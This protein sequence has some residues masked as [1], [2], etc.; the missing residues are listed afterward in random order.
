MKRSYL[1]IFLLLIPF[2]L[3]AEEPSAFGAGDLTSPSPY[4]LT[5][6]EE[7]LLQN[8]HNIRKVVVKSNNQANKVDSLRERIDGLQT[9]I[10][11]LSEKAHEN[12]VYI[13]KLDERSVQELKSSNEYEKRLSEITQKNTETANSNSQNIEKIK[14]VMSELSLLIDNINT[15]YVTKDEFNSLVNDVNNFKDLVAKELKGGYKSTTKE[16]DFSSMSKD[17]ISK[18]ARAYYDDKNYAKSIKYYMYLIEKG[19]KPARAHYMI[20]EMKYYTKEYSDAI[21]YFKKSASLYSKASY[22]PIL[23]FHTAISMEKVGD[24]KNAKAFFKGI[25]AKFPDTKY[26]KNAKKHLALMN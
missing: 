16:N 13:K 17:N 12:K 1:I 26:S 10:D 15:T 21:A 5:A 14:L 20:G 3:I 7:V 6:S 4:G 18:K 8:K 19:F 24:E 23:M 11:G 22:M 2:V 9:V 25:I